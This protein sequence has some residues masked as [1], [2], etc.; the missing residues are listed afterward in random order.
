MS[1]CALIPCHAERHLEKTPIQY[2]QWRFQDGHD[3]EFGLS[4]PKCHSMLILVAG[5]LLEK[6]TRV[7]TDADKQL[8]ETEFVGKNGAKRK[9]EVRCYSI[10]ILAHSR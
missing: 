8:L 1:C 6:A 10:V 5:E 2:I 4:S 9:L 7:L 3:R